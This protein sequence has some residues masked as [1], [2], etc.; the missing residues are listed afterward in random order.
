MNDEMYDS[1]YSGGDS[2]T[3]IS[4]VCW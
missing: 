1:W 2:I 4:W 3:Q